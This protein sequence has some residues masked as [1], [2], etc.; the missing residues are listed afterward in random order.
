MVFLI[1]VD[2]SLGMHIRIIL[3]LLACEGGDGVRVSGAAILS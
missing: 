1:H 3:P 2:M